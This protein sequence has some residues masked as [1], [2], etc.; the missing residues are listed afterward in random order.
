MDVHV[1]VNQNSADQVHG[2]PADGVDMADYGIRPIG[3][4]TLRLAL[5]PE[6]LQ[7]AI[8]MPTAGWP[9]YQVFFGR[10]PPIPLFYK[11]SQIAGLE[12]VGP[13]TTQNRSE[14]RHIVSIA[15]ARV[16]AGKASRMEW[17]M[18]YEKGDM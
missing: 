8:D 2:N 10:A 9:D 11:Q 6:D 1:T 15:L 14:G 17:L 12:R 4:D 18:M 3:E 13:A 16:G 5:A 7:N